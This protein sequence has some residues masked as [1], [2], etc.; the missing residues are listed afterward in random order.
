MDPNEERSKQW[1]KITIVKTYE[2]ASKRKE[3]LL[4]E[5]DQNLVKIK[6]C[7][8]DGTLFK[9]KLWHPEFVAP[10]KNKKNVKKR[11]QQRNQTS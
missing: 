7:G 3:T 8:P 5:D 11:R 10:K 1:K 9:V 4:A 6:R 2:E